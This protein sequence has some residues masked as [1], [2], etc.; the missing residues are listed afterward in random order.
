M[1]G[2]NTY[3]LPLGDI[4]GTSHGRTQGFLVSCDLPLEEVWRA[5]ARACVQMPS[6]IHPHNMFKAGPALTKEQVIS[7][8]MRYRGRE[9]PPPLEPLSPLWFARHVVWFFNQ[10]SERGRPLNMKLLRQ[11][12]YLSILPSSDMEMGVGLFVGVKK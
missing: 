11:K 6:R 2:K 10:G 1:K 8:R 7:L 5:Y 4:N 3:L 9:A 12:K